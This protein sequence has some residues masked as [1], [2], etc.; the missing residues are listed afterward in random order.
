MSGCA[1]RDGVQFGCYHAPSLHQVEIGLEAKEEPLAEPEVARKTK[2]GIGRNCPFAENNFVDPAR[3]TPSARAK[4]FWLSSAG[5]MNSSERISPGVGFGS[6]SLSLMVVD[7]FDIL[8]AS[9]LP[10][11]AHPPLVIDADA[12]LA[13]A[14]APQKFEPIAGW[15]FQVLQ[16][17]RLV[18]HTQFA[19]G[20]SLNVR[21]SFRLRRPDH[22]RL[23]SSSAKL[24]IMG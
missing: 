4:A 8:S 2:V 22:T 20:D 5:F 23:V 15:D 19:K 1:G 10:N 24:R 9:V 21:G 6:R 18:D 13:R 14:V 7:D 3:G 16:H 17:P 11:K 12:V